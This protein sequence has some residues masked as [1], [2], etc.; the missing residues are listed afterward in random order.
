M[1]SGTYE[2]DPDCDYG[3]ATP[4]LSVSY[5]LPDGTTYVLDENGSGTF[6]LEFYDASLGEAA[7]GSFS[8]LLRGDS[9]ATAEVM[10]GEFNVVVNR[11]Y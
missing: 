1:E 7:R 10:D 8:F 3:D 4:C 2:Y 6:T 5:T 9:T 11:D